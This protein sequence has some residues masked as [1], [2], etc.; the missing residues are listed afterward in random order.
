MTVPTAFIEHLLPG[1]VR[2]KIPARR[3]DVPYFNSVAQGLASN[4]RVAAV[5]V[6]AKTASI[7]VLHTGDLDS[8]ASIAAAG[9]L[10]DIRPHEPALERNPSR[11]NP[12]NTNRRA[13]KAFDPLAAMAV[14][15]SGLGVYQ[16]ARGQ[17]LSNA[18]ESMW[19]AYG[20]HQTLKKPS[21]AYAFVLLGLL[22]LI[23]GRLL[24][25]AS[26]LFFHA[27]TARHMSRE[28]SAPAADSTRHSGVPRSEP[29]I[30][31]HGRR[32]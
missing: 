32:P 3:G 12:G 28:K 13:S 10:F 1:R 17:T 23:R 21:V 19:Q 26:S 6:N 31:N 4:G 15:L 20:A 27:L 7:L 16:V 25:P 2:L 9:G 14:A 11:Q 30:H 29:G 8:I 22:Q 24:G 5:R 18:T